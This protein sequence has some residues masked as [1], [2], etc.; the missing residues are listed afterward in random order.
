M[1]KNKATHN[2][3]PKE[4]R[5]SVSISLNESERERLTQIAESQ[6]LSLSAFLRLAASKYI[7][8][9]VEKERS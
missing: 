5:A 6:G 9:E 1:S 7:A 3:T 4:K 8:T 2:Q